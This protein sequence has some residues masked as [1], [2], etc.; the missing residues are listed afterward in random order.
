MTLARK[1]D[2]R[3]RALFRIA[4][5][6]FFLAGTAPV[7]AAVADE[8]GD[9]R[10]L[11]QAVQDLREQVELLRTEV[12]KLATARSVEQVSRDNDA[13][14]DFSSGSGGGNGGSEAPRVSSSPGSASRGR[15]SSGY[16]HHVPERRRYYGY[17]PAGYGWPYH[18]AP[19]Y[20]YPYDY[21]LYYYGVPFYPNN[22]II[23][24]Y[25]GLWFSP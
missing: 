1:T 21:H 7:A 8:P 18:Y 12:R 20:V 13:D 25:Q 2:N 22:V 15:P 9:V 24:P 3:R 14:T 11:R 10:E 17:P 23:N 19:V 16:R 6:C 5:V 4:A